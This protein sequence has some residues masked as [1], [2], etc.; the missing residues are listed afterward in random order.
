MTWQKF[1]ATT[2]ICGVVGPLFWLG[3]KLLENAIR[4]LA[5]KLIARWRSK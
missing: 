2:V 5:N 4:S 3:I 1:V